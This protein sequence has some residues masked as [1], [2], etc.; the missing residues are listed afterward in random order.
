MVHSN[1]CQ[2]D[3]VGRG[4]YMVP[5]LIRQV[6]RPKSVS[7]RAVGNSEAASFQVRR[8]LGGDT[9]AGHR[10]RK[11]KPP[12]TAMLDFHSMSVI[13]DFQAWFVRR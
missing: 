1:T 2:T 10:H 7:A 5:E 11:K 9:R 6:M 12:T 13:S 8:S 3:V 4:I